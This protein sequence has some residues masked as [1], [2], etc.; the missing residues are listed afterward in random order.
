MPDKEF[1]S[2]EVKYNVRHSTFTIKSDVQKDRQ[3]QLLLEYLRTKMGS[4]A[5][6][7][8]P[9]LK[10]EYTITL[11]WF[12]EDDSFRINSDTGNKGLREGIL[13]KVVNRLG[14]I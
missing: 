8:A 6:N 5:D 10:E 3:A 4:G 9:N 14:D 12:A 13:M 11:Q 1:L 2:L 7:S